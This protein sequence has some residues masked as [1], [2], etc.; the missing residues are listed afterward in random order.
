VNSELQKIVRCTAFL[1]L[2]LFLRWPV[3]AALWLAGPFYLFQYLF[4]VYPGS[5][6]NLDG[7]YPRRLAK[8]WLFSKKPTIGGIISK[9]PGGRGL[10]L[11][12]PDTVRDFSR[13]PLTRT[14]VL[15]R[16]RRTSRS[17]GAGTIDLA[18]QLPGIYSRSGIS[19]SQ[20]FVTDD[21]GTVFC[22]METLNE[23]IKKNCLDR[24]GLKIAIVGVGYVGG[25]LFKA[26]KHDGFDVTG[27]DIARTRREIALGKTGR[28]VLGAADIVIA[29]TPNGSD[30][31]PYLPYL[32]RGVIIIDYTRPRIR[33]ESQPPNMAFYKVAVGV[34]AVHFQPRL[35]GYLQNWIPGCAVEAMVTAATG[36]FNIRSKEE[37]NR[38]A[39]ELGFFAHLVR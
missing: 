35:W 9:G 1:T 32:K 28:A 6:S 37:F 25:L 12:V 16:L 22:V 30:L 7:Y 14:A 13:S 15:N 38:Q 2:N 5:D 31:L 24:K 18:G 27:I 3:W 11:V 29:L 36:D 23:A 39:K 19:L 34:G 4:L 17:I 26:L 33:P 10:V 20:P 21:K 8:S